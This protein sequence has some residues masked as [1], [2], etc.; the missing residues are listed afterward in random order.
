MSIKLYGESILREKAKPVAEFGAELE[1]IV[2]DMK[3]KMVDVNGVGL[4]ANQVGLDIALFIAKLDEEVY[5]FTN[6][7]LV[8]L[9]T[10][11]HISEEG[12]LSVP[13]VWVDIERYLK[14]RLRAQDIKG[15]HVEL[16]LEGFAARV[17][18]HEVDHLNGVLIIDRISPEERRK[19]VSQL[20]KIQHQAL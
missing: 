10:E 14:V 11:S 13:G 16:E 18:Q 3:T 2:E 17:V 15:N 7:E 12:C 20:E 1:I 19:I 4:A 6:P 8:P 9:S 5:V